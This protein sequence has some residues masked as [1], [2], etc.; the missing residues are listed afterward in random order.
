MKYSGG[1]VV[2]N[3][4]KSGNLLKSK[5]FTRAY[6]LVIKKWDVKKN[7]IYS[8]LEFAIKSFIFNNFTKSVEY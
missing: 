7:R 1:I 3:S 4:C 2:R 5:V 6:E 8:T